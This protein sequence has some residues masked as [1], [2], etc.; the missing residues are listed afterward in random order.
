MLTKTYQD[1]VLHPVTVHFKKILVRYSESPLL[2]LTLMN[3]VK[4]DFRNSDP[5][6][7]RS[8]PFKTTCLVPVGY[9]TN[10]FQMKIRGSV[11]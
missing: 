11:K 10:R 6:N 8:V 3:A 1:N 5:W 9:S 2:H 7:S 4:T